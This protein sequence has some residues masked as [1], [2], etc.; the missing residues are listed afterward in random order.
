MTRALLP[1]AHTLPGVPA[2]EPG[3]SAC[4]IIRANR[5]QALIWRGRKPVLQ[6]WSKIQVSNSCHVYIAAF[7]YLR[8]THGNKGTIATY[9]SLGSL[10][11]HFKQLEV[12]Y[13]REHHHFFNFEP[14]SHR[15]NKDSTASRGIAMMQ[16][17][18]LNWTGVWTKDCH[19]LKHWRNATFGNI[20]RLF[21]SLLAEPLRFIAYRKGLFNQQGA[22][23]VKKH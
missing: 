9:I 4:S 21:S 14:V 11:S 18:F 23:E 15:S 6:S 7:H 22:T 8:W 1:Q 16:S 2:S 10:I 13:Y 19:L 3:T 12:L 17:H 5:R 20:I